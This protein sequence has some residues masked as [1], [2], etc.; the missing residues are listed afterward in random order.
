MNRIVI[1]T[2]LFGD[3]DDLKDPSQKFK[4]CDFV[5]FTD[6][7]NLKSNIWD[8]RYVDIRSQKPNVMNRKYKI[9][10][11]KYFPDHDISLYVD[12]NIRLVK[13]PTPLLHKY[14]S[15]NNFVLP[16]H[17]CRTCIYD[18]AVECIISK[19]GD[20]GEIARQ[21]RRYMREGFPKNFGLGENGILAR[22]HNKESVIC[23][24][25]QWWH[26]FQVGSERDQLSL[27]FVIWKKSMNFSFMNE[28]ARNRSGYFWIEKHNCEKRKYNLLVRGKNKILLNFRRYFFF[29]FRNLL[30]IFQ[31]M[32]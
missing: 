6:R 9:L 2:A 15:S 1:Y 26:E 13:D 19:K 28:S 20:P 10:T 29:K 27:A 12:A 24:M 7:A 18:E 22:R 14:L 32:S 11:H 21:I 8:I 3:Y 25:E 4:G 5:C 30:L 31:K 16:K 17:F 23:L